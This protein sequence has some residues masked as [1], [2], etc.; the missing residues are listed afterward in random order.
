M[1][2]GEYWIVD[3]E[4][5]FADGSIGDMDHAAYAL[6]H[7]RSLILSEF[8]WDDDSEMLCDFVVFLE[9]LE[10]AAGT[11]SMPEVLARL[12]SECAGLGTAFWLL[13]AAF[14]L[15]DAREA[16][17]RELGWKWVKKDWVG[18]FRLSQEDKDQIAEGINRILEEE[19]IE[20]G[21][22][23]ELEIRI[24]STGKSLC[25]SVGELLGGGTP[26]GHAGTLAVYCPQPGY[27]VALDMDRERLHFC[28][29]VIGD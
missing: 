26:G 10:S 24:L 23:D 15:E 14:L 9:A 16:A 25:L 3:G 6:Q 19:G 5:L 11:R 22:S 2:R 12:F 27:G 8:G 29:A 17:L 18:T 20:E 1:I 13:P 7:I 21:T 28:Y 4:P